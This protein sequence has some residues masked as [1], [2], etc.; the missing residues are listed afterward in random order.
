MSWVKSILFFT[1]AGAAFACDPQT[2]YQRHDG[3]CC[4]KCGPGT[5]MAE[6]DNNCL[7]PLCKP[8]AEDEYQMGYT[9][10]KLC[11]L[12]PY[13][14]PNKNLVHDRPV[15]KEKQSMC[16]CADGYHCSSEVCILC[17]AHS[18]CA[19]GQ[20]VREK[21]NHTHD[22]VCQDCPPNTYSAEE[23]ADSD[24][25][26]WT[27]CEPGS[28]KKILGTTTSDTV[29]EPMHRYHVMWIFPLILIVALLGVFA[30]L[31]LRG[32]EKNKQHFE[33]LGSDEP[34]PIYHPPEEETIPLPEENDDELVYPQPHMSSN[35]THPVTESGRVVAQERGKSYVVP[36]QES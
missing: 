17:V 13:C 29:C 12:Q 21:G 33:E 1:L 15:T 22:T 11:K 9:V 31:K 36:Q 27:V 3:Q 26:N 4:K 34:R 23:T 5:R 18:H 32:N 7:D 25:H 20:G 6:N 14:D 8:C 16:R 24:C 28:K 35:G 30:Y 19:A 2:Q 10:N